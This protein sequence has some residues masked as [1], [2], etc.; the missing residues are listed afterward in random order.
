M[1]LY[2]CCQQEI[3]DRDLFPIS[4]QI[5]TCNRRRPFTP[6]KIDKRVFPEG[7]DGLEKNYLHSKVQSNFLI[8]LPPKR[9]K[10]SKT[11]F[12]S[13]RLTRGFL[14]LQLC[15]LVRLYF[16]SVNSAPCLLVN[17]LFLL[18]MAAVHN[19]G[20][21]QNLSQLSNSPENLYLLTRILL[22]LDRLHIIS[23]TTQCFKF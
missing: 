6:D 11:S 22:N 12:P 18:C 14:F 9:G 13:T 15:L 21:I 10:G 4:A 5:L 23:A 16:P 1:L 3:K 20:Y 8:H 2:L 17:V 19:G 7:T